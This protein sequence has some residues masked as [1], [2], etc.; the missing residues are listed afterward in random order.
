[1]KF[2]IDNNLSHLLARGM[3]EFGE[4]V[5]HLQEQFAESAEDELWLPYIGDKGYVLVTR[6]ETIRWK[7]AEIK[8]LKR[9]KVGAF[10]LGGKGLSRCQLV[11]QLVRN[12]PRMKELAA[13]EHRPFAYRIP[14]SGTKFVK[15]EL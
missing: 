5:T 3:R 7:P 12:W 11:Q 4:D 15:I 6:D 14:P 1:M 8:A 10:F 9:H 13:K 2:F